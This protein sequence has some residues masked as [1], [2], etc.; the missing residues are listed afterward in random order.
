MQDPGAFVKCA[1]RYR[2][3]VWFHDFKLNVRLAKERTQAPAATPRCLRPCFSGSTAVP[4]HPA[5]NHCH[6]Q[7]YSSQRNLS[8]LSAFL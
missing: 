3:R 2:L 6:I 7:K 4:V 1:C 5:S 8:E